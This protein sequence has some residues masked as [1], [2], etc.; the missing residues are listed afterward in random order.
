MLVAASGCTVP[1]A[2]W[3]ELPTGLGSQLRVLAPDGLPVS[4]GYVIVR[5]YEYNGAG[6]AEGDPNIR[7]RQAIDAAFEEATVT[8]QVKEGTTA[9][10]RLV[11]LQVVPVGPD[12]MAHLP[13]LVEAGT[14]WLVKGSDAERGGFHRRF[15]FAEVQALAAGYPPSARLELAAGLDQ[16]QMGASEEPSAWGRELQFAQQDVGRA[17]P[18][19]FVLRETI[20]AELAR[21]APDTEAKRRGGAGSMPDSW[22]VGAGGASLASESVPR[23]SETDTP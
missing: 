14:L 8:V 4:E 11:R 15:H 12:G 18:D 13:G 20:D 5:V 21:L 6:V 23:A 19:A 10:Y 16:L 2:V 17:N 22:A 7:N 1:V 9:Q 3:V